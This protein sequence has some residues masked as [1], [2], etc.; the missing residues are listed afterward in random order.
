MQKESNQLQRISVY[1]DVL[2]K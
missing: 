1:N 2:I